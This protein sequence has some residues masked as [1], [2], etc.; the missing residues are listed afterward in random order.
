MQRRTRFG[1]QRNQEVMFFNMFFNRWI[2]AEKV[3]KI[4]SCGGGY[5][6]LRWPNRFENSWSKLPCPVESEELRP[7]VTQSFE[8][9]V[10]NS[11]EPSTDGS[12]TRGWRPLPTTC[13]SLMLFAGKFH[14]SLHIQRLHFAVT[15]E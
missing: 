5:V 13:F 6:V 8:Q 14:Q 10:D 7:F 9:W 2:K 15:K 12:R 3:M 11:I 4:R 1:E